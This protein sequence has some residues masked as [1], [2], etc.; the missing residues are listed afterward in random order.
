MELQL[1]GEKKNYA[2]ISRIDDPGV[3]DFLM[4]DMGN[5]VGVEKSFSKKLV[6][7]KV[8]FLLIS[9]SK[10]PTSPSAAP[11]PATSTTATARWKPKPSTKISNASASSPTKPASPPLIHS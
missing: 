8:F 6:E 4:R 5:K 1:N 2:P 10:A 7:L 9:H 11:K 3:I